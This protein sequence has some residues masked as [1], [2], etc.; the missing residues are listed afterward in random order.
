MSEYK[1]TTALSVG[2]PEIDNDHQELF[3]LVDEMVDAD[4]SDSFLLGIIGRL[5]KYT[6][7]HF[8][9]EED[10]MRENGYPG[11]AEHIEKHKLFV[12]WL[13]TV[14]QTYRRAAESPFQ[15]A[16]LVNDFLGTWL[17]EHIM[18]EDMQYRDFIVQR[19]RNVKKS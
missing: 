16:D 2:D 15:I 13:K 3:A 6:E 19:M 18:H 9:R 11:L 5:E 8:A 17:V 14:E 12:E 1:W 4:L 7:Y 10:Y